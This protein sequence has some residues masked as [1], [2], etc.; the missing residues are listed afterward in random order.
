MLD[1]RRAVR[2]GQGKAWRPGFASSAEPAVGG[3]TAVASISSLSAVRQQVARAAMKLSPYVRSLLLLVVFLGFTC[4]EQQFAFIGGSHTFEAKHHGEVYEIILKRGKDKVAE[5]DS[6]SNVEQY[7]PP[8][9]NRMSLNVENGS[10]TASQL[11]RNDSDTYTLEW[12]DAE[13]THESSTLL[14]V[15]DLLLELE[16]N[17]NSTDN[18]KLRCTADSRLPVDCT[19]TIGTETL[20]GQGSEVPIPAN[21]PP[22]TVLM[23]FSVLSGHERSAQISLD[24]CLQAEEGAHRPDLTALWVVLILLLLLLV[25]GVAIY[26]YKKGFRHCWVKSPEKLNSYGDTLEQN[27]SLLDKCGS[28]GGV[29]GGLPP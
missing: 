7:Y 3:D 13:G 20:P 10:V 22:S 14:T 1:V 6:S 27:S 9:E 25:L 4:C 2:A 19:C 21:R 15:A 18:A 12:M 26:L 23:C 16:M 29:N 17:C 8:F 28:D 24:P 5:W 11:E